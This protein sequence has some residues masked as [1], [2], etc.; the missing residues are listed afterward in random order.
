MDKHGI[1]VDTDDST[2]LPQGKCWQ[3]DAEHIGKTMVSLGTWS[4]NSV[5]S[6][7]S[8]FVCSFEGW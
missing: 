2:G 7:L 4:R 8:I 1:G 5:S 3:R 6:G